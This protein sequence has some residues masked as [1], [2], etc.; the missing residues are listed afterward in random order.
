MATK[1]IEIIYDINGKAIDVAVDKTLNLKK[2]IVE[3]TKALRSAKEGSDE[4]K[5]L[6]SRLSDTQDALGKTTAKS[7]DLFG[8]LSMLP[9]PVGQFASQIQSG[10]ELLKTFSS[11][12]L[13]DLQFQFKE[14]ANDIGDIG[15]N[16]T[17]A[18]NAAEGGVAAVGGATTTGAAASGAAAAGGIAATNSAIESR[19]KLVLVSGELVTAEEAMIAASNKSGQSI[20]NMTAAELQLYNAQRLAAKSAAE[21]AGATEGLVVA[22]KA[23]TFWTTTLGNT[24]KTVL[25]STGILA[26]IVIIGELVSLIYR[27][28]T[29]TE[30]AEAATRSLTAAIVEQ[31]RV[32]ENDLSAIDMANKAAVTRAKIAGQTEKEIN[33]IVKNGGQERLQRL[34][35]YDNE[36]YKLQDDLTKNTKIKAEDREKLS[37]DINEKILK[38]GQDITKQIIGN[39][40]TRLEQELALKEKQRAKTKE[41]N[42]KAIAANKEYQDKLK[43]DNKTADEALLKLLDEN[44]ALRQTDKRKREDEELKSA[45]QAEERT[46][47]MLKISE[48]KKSIIINQIKV[49]YGLKVLDINAKRNEED[50]AKQK[51][52]DEKVLDWS[53]KLAEMAVLAIADQTE[54]EKAEKR[55]KYQEDLTSLDKAFKDKLVTQEQ[56]NQ[57]VK[58]LDQALANDLK[59]I[60]DDTDT[61]AKEDKLKKLDDELKFLQILTDAEKNSFV[62]Y[63]VDR[64]KVLDKAK[65]RE[66][67]EVEAGSEKAHIIEKKYAQLYKDLQKE[68]LDAYIAMVGQALSVASSFVSSQ[69]NLNSLEQQNEL[70]NAK[71]TI[72]NKE[73][74]AKEEDKIKEKY[75]YR[76][77]DAQ[78]AQAAISAFQAAISAYASLAVIPVVGP[79]LGAVAAAAALV[80]GNKQVKAINAQK[81][82]SSFNMPSENGGGAAAPIPN[83][84]K[85]YADG[86]LIG[87]RRHAQGGTMIEAEAGEAV[88]TRGA[89]TMFAPLLSLMNQAGGGTS[90]STNMMTTSTDAPKSAYPSSDNKSPVFKTYVVSNELTSEAQKQARLKDLSTL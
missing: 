58:N 45:M 1:K 72:A 31:Q 84:K 53:N 43:A 14:T 9:G 86:G 36:L 67:A 70:D 62:A 44:A 76:N 24:I 28:V 85:N 77:R 46:I 8:S 51:E 63:W 69:Q 20:A 48:E 26:A 60:Q 27:W 83:Y 2:Q 16:I 75:F 74:L 13:K 87:G 23:A 15:K 64:K 78:A 34:R 81:Y 59:K 7:K 35:D 19:K 18:K 54:K 50:L 66:L 17:G 4:F 49:K 80:F 61:K 3:L 30:D 25:I 37:K 41:F 33:E 65:E 88:M 47:N 82:V 11:F 89:V 71:L 55:K 42:D 6:S 12:T 21:Q 73:D 32:L 5:V 79:Y 38:N 40:Q 90:F 56:Y 68:K 29:S 39:E 57:A 22:E 10:I 52:H